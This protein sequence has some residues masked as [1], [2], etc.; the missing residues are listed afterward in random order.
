MNKEI[1]KLLM[2]LHPCFDT[3]V[4]ER[5]EWFLNE[6][7]N[8]CGEIAICKHVMGS[9]KIR[10]NGYEIK[11]KNIC[12]DCYKILYKCCK[13]DCDNKKNRYF[14]YYIHEYCEECNECHLVITDYEKFRGY[15]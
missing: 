3:L 2:N 1:S 9:R 6:R 15:V 12:K 13:I 14:G 10:I 5:I 8:M 7:C 11:K 4:L